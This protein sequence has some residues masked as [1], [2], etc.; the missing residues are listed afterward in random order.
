MSPYELILYTLTIDI[1][2]NA[3]YLFKNKLLKT[4]FYPLYNNDDYLSC[5][6][7]IKLLLRLEY[8]WKNAQG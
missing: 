5:L 1:D 6:C 4:A 8:M 2:R 7:A 3:Y